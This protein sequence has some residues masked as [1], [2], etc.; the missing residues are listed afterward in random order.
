MGH[1]SLPLL[2][3]IAGGG[4][5][6]L[7]ALFTDSVLVPVGPGRG[8]PSLEWG[9]GGGSGGPGAPTFSRV[10]WCQGHDSDPAAAAGDPGG[11][12]GVRGLSPLC[13]LRRGT[14]AGGVP[15]MPNLQ[16]GYFYPGGGLSGVRHSNP[17]GTRPRRG[18]RRGFRTPLMISVARDRIALLIGRAE[19]V[20]RGGDPAL[21]RRY[22]ELARRIGTRYNIRIPP[23]LK[24]RFCQGCSSFFQEGI[25]V[26]TRLNFGRRTRTCLSCGRVR[27]G[28]IRGPPV[29][30]EPRGFRT[31]GLPEPL[32]VSVDEEEDL[33]EEEGP[34][35]G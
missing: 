20:S 28:L 35:D 12:P 1:G 23:L 17:S 6:L 22:V 27:R 10:S 3:G 2:S 9:S 24:E 15:A 19:E 7:S 26:R 34:E 5:G 25:T 30:E 32:A 21:S 8:A 18:G 14:L 13:P 29:P 11:G 16:R 31:E 33:E 4:S